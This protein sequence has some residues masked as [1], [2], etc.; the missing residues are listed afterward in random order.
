MF[1]NEIYK[2]KNGYLF[3]IMSIITSILFLFGIFTVV[4]G[5]LGYQLSINNDYLPMLFG[6]LCIIGIIGFPFS[7]ALY[8]GMKNLYVKSTLK[9]EDDKIIYDKQASYEWT[10]VGHV[11]EK[12]VFIIKKIDNFNIS[13]RWIKVYGKIEKTVINNN[14]QLEK[15]EV[16]YVKIARSFETDD[17]IIKYLYN[18]K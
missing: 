12:H 4:C 14:K 7:L 9:L 18:L 11:N 6:W 8:R 16:S 15:K 3:V 5:A 10:A 13:N 1:S 17:E 2:K